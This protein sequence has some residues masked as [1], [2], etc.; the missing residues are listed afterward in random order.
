MEFLQGLRSELHVTLEEGPEWPVCTMCSSPASGKAWSAIHA[1]ALLKEGS[2]GDKVDPRK[3]A[4][5][6]RRTVAR[7]PPR[8]IWTADVAGIGA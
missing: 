4:A 6:L 1:A 5:P 2:K 3:L 7:G 8:R